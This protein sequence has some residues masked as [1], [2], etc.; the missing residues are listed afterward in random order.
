MGKRAT[1][2]L[3]LVLLALPAYAGPL[4]CQGGQ[5][6]FCSKTFSASARCTGV[7]ELAAIHGNACPLG[8]I[9]NICPEGK[10]CPLIEPW[11]TVPILIHGVEIALIGGGGVHYALA[12]NSY[13]PDIMAKL[14]AGHTHRQQWF[15]AGLGFRLPK[16]A[17]A[18]DPHTHIDLHVACS[19]APPKRPSWK[20]RLLGLGCRPAITRT[21]QFLY[22][23]YYTVEPEAAI[24][25]EATR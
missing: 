4:G 3:L 2:W 24:S 6:T 15:P 1:L 16:R 7:D 23:L 13:V 12:G 8:H 22:T 14:G 9:C 18:G 21:A 10:E 5:H 19:P 11:E 20:C 17:A 25:A